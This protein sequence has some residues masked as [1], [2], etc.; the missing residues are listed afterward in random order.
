LKDRKNKA[1]E[2]Q[3]NKEEENRNI[4]DNTIN[5]NIDI[6]SQGTCIEEHNFFGDLKGRIL[7][8]DRG[9]MGNKA[10]LCKKTPEKLLQEE[11]KNNNKI[12]ELL[13]KKPNCSEIN[14][15]KIKKSIEQTIA[16]I[17]NEGT[18]EVW[19]QKIVTFLKDTSD[20]IERMNTKK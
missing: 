8:E 5:D 17:E 7:V 6:E 11:Y 16:Q 15:V 12:L 2:E 14:Y 4:I 19:D 18:R 20:S 13:S 1:I 10:G 3:R 9:F